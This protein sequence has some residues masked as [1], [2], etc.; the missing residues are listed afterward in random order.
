MGKRLGALLL[1]LPLSGAGCLA[2]TGVTEARAESYYEGSVTAGAVPLEAD[3]VVV[4]DQSIELEIER[5]PSGTD[6]GTGSAETRTTL[7]NPTDL[8]AELHMLFPQTPQ[9]EGGA[10]DGDEYRVEIDGVPVRTE[11]RHSYLGY[12]NRVFDL[13]AG[14]AQIAAGEA[15]GFYGDSGLAVNRYFFDVDLPAEAFEG[16][17]RKYL[18]FVLTFDCNPEKTRVMSCNRMTAETV[19]GRVQASFDVEAGKNEICL[20]VAGEDVGHLTYGVFSGRSLEHKIEMG[21]FTYSE[22]SSTLEEYAMSYYPEGSEISADDWYSGFVQM[23]SMSTAGYLVYK[24]PSSLRQEAF[25][26]WLEYTVTVPPH[27][28]VVQT[29]HAPLYPRAGEKSFDYFYMLSSQQRW[30]SFGSVSI[31][32]RTPFHLAYSTLNFEK[33]GDGYVFKRNCLPV[34]D[35][36]FTVTETEEDSLTISGGLGY[37]PMSPSLRLAYILIGSLAGAAAIGLLAWFV[38]SKKRKKPKGKER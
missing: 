36:N 15:G 19:N 13:D 1:A 31:S 9:K 20:C 7:F 37:D 14:L 21:Q 2:V 25:L 23:L 27:G 28:R 30:S 38:V 26:K 6:P 3:P 33:S 35:L 18:S 29:T 17:G 8:S 11:L 16:S 24:N 4:E 34:G 10:D 32:I 22:T 5:L 12:Y